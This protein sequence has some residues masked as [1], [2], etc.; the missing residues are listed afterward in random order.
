ML[1]MDIFKYLFRDK[2]NDL[3]VTGQNSNITLILLEKIIGQNS[4]PLK[5]DMC[6][7]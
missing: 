4:L 3:A 2:Y 1:L 7:K 6:F 5:S